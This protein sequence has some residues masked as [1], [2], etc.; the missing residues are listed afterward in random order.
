MLAKSAPVPVSAAGRLEILNARCVVLAP[1]DG[2]AD[3]VL[4]DLGTDH[5]G[6]IGAVCI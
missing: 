2:P 6:E 4:A 3:C 1:G 5:A